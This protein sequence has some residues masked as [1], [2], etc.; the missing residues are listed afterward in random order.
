MNDEI[1]S[2]ARKKVC[3]KQG[4]SGLAA[5]AV[6]WGCGRSGPVEWGGRVRQAR[7]TPRLHAQAGPRVWVG[8]A[9]RSVIAGVQVKRIAQLSEQMQVSWRSLVIFEILAHF[10]SNA[11]APPLLPRDP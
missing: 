11:L 9:V 4:L 7:R 8:G 2:T 5:G 1:N 10:R 6:A 3:K